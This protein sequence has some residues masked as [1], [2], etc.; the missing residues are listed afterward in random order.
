MDGE[1]RLNK[2]I[3]PE[4]RGLQAYHVPDAKGLIKL[5]AMENPYTWPDALLDRWLDVVRQVELNRYPD[6]SA[7]VLKQHL[8]EAM[9]IPAGAEIL[10]GNGSDEIIQMILLALADEQRTVLSVEPGFVMYHM[11]ATFADMQ[12]IGVPLQETSSSSRGPVLP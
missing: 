11:I 7:R 1:A 4:I 2:W 10:L 12:Y 8:R 3:R 9:A 5:D 6:P